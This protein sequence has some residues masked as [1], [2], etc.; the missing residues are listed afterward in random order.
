MEFPAT[1][2]IPNRAETL[3]VLRLVGE[4]APVLM[5]TGDADGF[6]T[7]WTVDGQQIQP[8]IA[9]YL[10]EQGFLT[11]SGATE[12]GARKLVLTGVGVRFREDGI[13]WWERLSLLQRL[14]VTVFG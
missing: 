13:A 4:F 9:R 10:M 5:L 8:A 1:T 6:G 11:E 3:Q 14:K 12:F 2:A 7:R